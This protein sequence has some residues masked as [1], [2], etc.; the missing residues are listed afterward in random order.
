VQVK[1]CQQFVMRRAEHESG[2]F[3]RLKNYRGIRS[4]LHQTTPKPFDWLTVKDNLLGH[5]NPT[6]TKRILALT[7]KA[8][9]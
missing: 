3:P 4:L 2:F 9:I 6:S 5:L 7:S 8:A 1:L